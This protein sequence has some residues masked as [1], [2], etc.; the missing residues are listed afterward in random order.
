MEPMYC[1]QCGLDVRPMADG[2]EPVIE[3]KADGTFWYMNA[4]ART[5][6]LTR[7]A[8]GATDEDGHWLTEFYRPIGRHWAVGRCMADDAEQARRHADLFVRQATLPVGTVIY[9]DD[10]PT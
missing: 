3:N 8:H 2:E 5:P 7:M 9:I 1:P 4:M 10:P 6:A